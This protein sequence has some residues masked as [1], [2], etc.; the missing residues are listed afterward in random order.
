[1]NVRTT[2]P[3]FSILSVLIS[4]QS[5][6]SWDSSRVPEPMLAVSVIWSVIWHYP[7]MLNIV[8]RLFRIMS[9]RPGIG[10]AY[11]EKMGHFHRARADP[12]VYDFDTPCAM[13]RFYMDKIFTPGQRRYIQIKRM[14]FSHDHPMDVC[15][16]EHERLWKKLNRKNK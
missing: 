8:N 3:L 12:V 1:M 5:T 10:S 16:V 4:L 13:P 15:P 14:K 7:K 11:V 2:M 9:R 6:G